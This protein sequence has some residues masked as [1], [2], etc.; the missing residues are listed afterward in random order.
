[1]NVSVNS[2][3][4]NNSVEK[5]FDFKKYDFEHF[6]MYFRDINWFEL[7]YDENI[8]IDGLRDRFMYVLRHF[9]D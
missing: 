6:S 5:V 9:V 2:T 8:D 4:D 3:C 1:M 7:L